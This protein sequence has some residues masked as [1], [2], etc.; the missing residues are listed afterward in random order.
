M[1]I[2]QEE[3]LRENRKLAEQAAKDRFDANRESLE[4]LRGEV[5]DDVINEELA[6]NAEEYATTLAE[7]QIQFN[8][9]L[10]DLFLTTATFDELIAKAA[11]LRTELED[12]L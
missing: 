1:T 2:T 4:E 10:Q 3:F 12:Q 11:E 8:N 6:R 7:I 9:D 5:S